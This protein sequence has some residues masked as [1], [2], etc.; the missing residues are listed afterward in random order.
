MII[1]VFLSCLSLSYVP[2]VASFSGLSFFL[3]VASVFS[4]VG[5]LDYFRN[6]F[7]SFI[8]F[9]VFF[10]V[11]HSFPIF[12]GYVIVSPVIYGS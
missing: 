8:V 9:C 3:I 1:I 4:N 2:Y 5:T 11:G 6:N 10:F 7:A 12:C